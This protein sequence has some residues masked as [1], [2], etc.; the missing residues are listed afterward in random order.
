MLNSQLCAK[1]RQWPN[2]N[3]CFDI[4]TDEQVNKRKI[5]LRLADPLADIVYQSFQNVKHFSIQWTATFRDI[6]SGRVK[7]IY[8]VAR[9]KRVWNWKWQLLLLLLLLLLLKSMTNKIKY[10]WLIISVGTRNQIFRDRTRTQN[11]DSSITR[12]VASYLH[13]DMFEPWKDFVEIIHR[14][15][16]EAY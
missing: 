3:D 15:Y 6:T 16:F 7:R 12:Y 5:S 1:K 8:C 14:E 9:L 4:C 10:F 2:S 11:Q 13:T